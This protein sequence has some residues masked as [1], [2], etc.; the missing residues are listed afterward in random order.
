MKFFSNPR[1]GVVVK[2][3]HA[4]NFS[5]AVSDHAVAVFLLRN[6][7][8]GK[9]RL[10]AI[11][12][13]Q[14]CRSAARW[15]PDIQQRPS[16]PPRKQACGGATDTPVRPGYNGVFL[17]GGQALANLVFLSAIVDSS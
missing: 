13:D 9:D 2:D 5:R 3:I 16:L 4:P 6:V 10:P 17:A 11:L 7:D 8:L 15:F 14:L 12:L 1:P